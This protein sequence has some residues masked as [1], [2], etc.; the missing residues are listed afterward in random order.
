MRQRKWKVTTQTE[1]DADADGQRPYQQRR[2][3]APVSRAPET[4]KSAGSRGR[5]Q[6][7]TSSAVSLCTFALVKQEN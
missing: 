2:S 4:A 6:L 5:T 7:P 1:T 3:C